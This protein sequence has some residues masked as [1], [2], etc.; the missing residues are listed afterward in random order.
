M[1]HWFRNPRQPLG[2]PAYRLGAGSRGSEVGVISAG[3]AASGTGLVVD[4][5]KRL[6]CSVR[7]S[8]SCLSWETSFSLCV[9]EPVSCRKHSSWVSKRRATSAA[10]MFVG[11]SIL[12]RCAH[13]KQDGRPRG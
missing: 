3:V 9:N 4:T 8:T 2:S 6:T 10:S 5:V 12:S 13:H 1:K 7:V 11:L